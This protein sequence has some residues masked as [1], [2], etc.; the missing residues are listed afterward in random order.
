[1]LK[2]GDQAMT[3]K[4][5][6]IGSDELRRRSEEQ[7]GKMTGTA[8]SSGTEEEPLR[9]RHELQVH[10]VELDM[11]NEELRNSRDELEK[12]LEE[13]TELY[14]FAPV[15]YVTLDLKGTIRKVNF[16]GAALLGLVRSS[17]V[18]RRFWQF[19]TD[20][21]CPVFTA[22]LGKV[23][24]GP[25][26][27]ECEL[28]L[29]KNGHA[30]V[31]VQVVGRVTKPG[32][33]CR[34][35][36]IDITERK[37]AEE[38]LRKKNAD[39][40]QFLYTVSHD[41]RSPLVTVKTFM[42]YLEKDITDGNQEHLTQD[43][44]FIHGAAD[45]MKLML[46]ELLELSRIGRVE[47]PMVRVSL[48]DVLAETVAILAGIISERKVDISRPD[49]DLMLSGDHPRLCQIWQNLIENAIKYSRDGRIPRIELGVR[50]MG[51]ET[52]FFVRDNGIG[53][54]PQFHSK[55]FGIFEKLDP[56]SPGAGLGLSMVMRIVEKF[57]GRIWVE[58]EGI[59]KGSCFFFTL[60]QALVQG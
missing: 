34:I 13:Y 5:Q 7:I 50:Q 59:D 16:T 41:L 57:G 44:Q 38:I 42:G 23:F 6:S 52:V 56:K 53:I 60:P 8:L 25:N 40:E 29:L 9:L 24:T 3:E 12:V 18:G 54:D 10:Q 49:T 17:L 14:D 37:R 35:A 33:E 15:G 22:F 27:E 11:Q 45:K 39:I 46:D 36:L 48:R 32:Q 1:V 2:N 55:I 28:T 58:S 26:K 19:M 47:S 20:E 43:I 31:C 4:V 30:P 51:G 21:A